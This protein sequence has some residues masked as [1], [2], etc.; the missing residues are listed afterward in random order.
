MPSNSETVLQVL[1]DQGPL[2]SKELVERTGLSKRAVSGA[3]GRLVENG[4]AT[5]SADGTVRPK[6][7]K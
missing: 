7:K 5:R 3:I 6:E 1:R 4:D 2:N